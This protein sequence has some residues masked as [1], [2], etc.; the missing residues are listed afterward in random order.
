ML[1][2]MSRAGYFNQ[3]YVDDIDDHRDNSDP[4]ITKAEPETLPED[5]KSSCANLIKLLKNLPLVGHISV[6][7]HIVDLLS[8]F[9]Y[10][11]FVPKYNMWF[12]VFIIIFVVVP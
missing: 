6:F 1:D 9:L 5:K 12:N 11:I 3:G 7:M 8:D 10:V 2:S 4:L